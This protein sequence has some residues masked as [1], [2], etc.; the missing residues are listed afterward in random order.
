MGLGIGDGDNDGDFDIFVTHWLAQENALYADETR[1]MKVTPAAPLRFVD[2]AD[3]LGLGQIALDAIGWG[4]GFLDIDNDGWLDL[5]AVN[6]STFQ[7]EADPTQLIPMRSFL[8]WNSGGEGFFEI[9]GRS[10]EPFT[11]PAVGR[12]ASFADYDDDGDLDI[13][14]VVHGGRLR[15]A[16]NEHG[17]R[18]G[19]VRLVL[20]ASPE[21]RPAEPDGTLRRSTTFAT[22][23]R[24]R[25]TT[26]DKTQM[27]TVGGQPSYL[28]Q[29][30]PGE[31]FFGT[32]DAPRIDRLEVRWPSGRVQTF[33]GL[34]AR[35]TIRILEGGEPQV[36]ASRR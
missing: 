13:A 25:L 28:S 14:I 3:L 33:A 17:N 12:G 32:G 18:R 31:V 4:T 2:Q 8:F 19:W 16:R 29:E 11:A 23:A 27:R 36:A 15:L 6:G 22:G 30:P 5:Y 24:V 7:E 35:S 1:S 20:R 10:G 21:A 34:P 26:G 9:G